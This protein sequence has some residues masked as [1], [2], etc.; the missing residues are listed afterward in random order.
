M[1]DASDGRDKEDH[2][3]RCRDEAEAEAI[4]RKVTDGF[5]ESGAELGIDLVPSE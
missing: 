1:I 3:D 2:H 4:Y 5:R